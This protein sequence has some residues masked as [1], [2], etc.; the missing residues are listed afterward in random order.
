MHSVVE[1]ASYSDIET[2]TELMAG[3][4]ESLGAKDL[5]HQSLK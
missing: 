1:M 4:V 2:T 5:F 3:F